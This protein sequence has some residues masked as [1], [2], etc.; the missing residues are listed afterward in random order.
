MQFPEPKKQPILLPVARPRLKQIT[1]DST[2]S[3]RG[4][5]TSTHAEVDDADFTGGSDYT[6]TTT[7][8]SGFA[9]A[10]MLCKLPLQPKASTH[11]Q[12]EAS[13]GGYETMTSAT[14]A[15]YKS[16]NKETVEGEVI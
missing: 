11:S 14:A 9:E 16:L 3:T 12:P 8:D 4:P 10:A 2:Q 13:S 15:Y 6:G 7:G 1:H 5:T